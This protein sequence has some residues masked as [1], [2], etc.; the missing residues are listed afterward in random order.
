MLSPSITG[1]LASLSGS[2]AWQRSNTIGRSE[3]EA[4]FWILVLWI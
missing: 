3:I 1:V 2:G 4:V